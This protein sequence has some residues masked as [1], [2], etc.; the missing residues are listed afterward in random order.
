MLCIPC[1]L[2]F[3][4]YLEAAQRGANT[5]VM[6]GGPGTC[7][8]G[9]SCERH[10][11]LLAALGYPCQVFTLDLL[12]VQR[13]LLRITRELTTGRPLRTLFEPFRMLVALMRTVDRV[14][15]A[16]LTLRPRELEPG[17]IDRAL[18]AAMERLVKARSRADLM[19]EADEIIES[20]RS[21]PHDAKMRVLRVGL[22]GH[23]YTRLTPF[24]NFGLER[25]LGRLG[26][27]VRRW[28]ALRLRVPKP[29]L[30]AVLRSDRQA[31][32]M[33]AG[34]AFLSHD[35]GGFA[36]PTVGE[37]ALMADGEVDGLVHVAPFNCTPEMVA[38][39]ALVAL[40]ADMGVPVLHLSFDEQTA[41]AGVAT[42]LE[43]FIDM[44]RAR[45]RRLGN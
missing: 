37:A 24:L 15:S 23:M 13:D 22:V 17:S 19:S 45:E 40:Q 41:E 34:G 44:I 5:I 12:N 2:L 1:K 3:G 20:V 36:R 35:V 14:E 26:V 11:R 7:R 16:A 8:L 4:N 25:E 43:A 30:P 38:Q 28:F 21:V 33:R 6:L 27:E 9:Y 29:V 32:A 31:K 18:N 39:S 10:R 42:R